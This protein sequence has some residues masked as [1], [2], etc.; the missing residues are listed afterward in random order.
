VPKD[1]CKCPLCGSG[2]KALF[3]T[4]DYR[5][6]RETQTWEVVWCDSCRFGKIDAALE[7]AEVSGFYRADYYTHK[8]GDRQTVSESLFDKARLHLA[9]RFDNGTDLSPAEFKAPG[10]LCDIG[11]GNGSNLQKFKEA[12]FKVVGVEPDDEARKI[13]NE[14]APVYAGT[15]ESLPTTL[16]GEQD[17]VLLSHVLEHTISPS[18]ALANAYRLLKND[19]MLVVEVPNNDALG[20][21]IFGQFWPWADVPRHINFFTETSLRKVLESAGFRISE[22]RYLGYARQFSSEWIADQQ[23]IWTQI[24][25]R[26]VPRPNFSRRAWSLLARTLISSKSHK[27]DSIRI[28]AVKG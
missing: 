3:A 22:I 13:A 4:K 21:K 1:G 11:C 17:Y 19:G 24:G 25:E 28:H 9:W 7:P 8:L 10:K 27:Y 12:G 20:F 14:V 16:E 18:V 26:A 23:R 5:R 2:M 15:G 6:P